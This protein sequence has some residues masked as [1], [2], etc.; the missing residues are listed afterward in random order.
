MVCQHTADAVVMIVCHSCHVTV[1][2]LRPQLLK[3]GSVFVAQQ[4]T[5]RGATA[6]WRHRAALQVLVSVDISALPAFRSCVFGSLFRLK[7][8][9]AYALFSITHVCHCM[10][11]TDSHM[12]CSM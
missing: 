5:A 7:V 9:G 4:L 6:A 2:V 1:H 10:R 11:N 8:S 3:Q 12:H